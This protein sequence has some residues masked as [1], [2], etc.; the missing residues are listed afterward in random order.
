[1]T[2]RGAG[3]PGRGAAPESGKLQRSGQA[4]P[5]ALAMLDAAGI[6]LRTEVLGSGVAGAAGARV[7][8]GVRSAIELLGAVREQVAS[9]VTLP[10]GMQEA[11]ARFGSEAELARAIRAGDL[12]SDLATVRD[13]LLAVLG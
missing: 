1:M 10:D 4:G 13:V 2:R 5:D 12:D 7:R 6:L 11:L 8:A 3:A 9:G